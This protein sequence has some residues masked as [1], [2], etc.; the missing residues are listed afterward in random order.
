MMNNNN[1]RR[2]PAEQAHIFLCNAKN[3]L[4]FPRGCL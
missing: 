1:G 4:T 3:L 2:G